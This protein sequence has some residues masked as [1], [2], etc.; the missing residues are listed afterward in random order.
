MTN[1]HIGSHSADGHVELVHS[2]PKPQIPHA[3]P[4][5]GLRRHAEN[6]LQSPSKPWERMP[7]KERMSK[8]F[9]V[10]VLS[11]K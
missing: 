4:C 6:M 8:A 11:A 10:Q 5:R 3:S 1:H 9:M 7:E 2:V